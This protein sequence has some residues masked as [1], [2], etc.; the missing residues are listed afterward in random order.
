MQVDVE[1]VVETN[2]STRGCAAYLQLRD[3]SFA[4]MALIY[5]HSHCAARKKDL[6]V[7]DREPP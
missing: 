6:R 1:D 5:F 3:E 4:L 7:L 2:G